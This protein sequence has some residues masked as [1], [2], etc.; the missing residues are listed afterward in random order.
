M[1]QG[2]DPLAQ[3]EQKNEWEVMEDC[4]C[5]DIDNVAQADTTDVHTLK[6]A[7]ET[8]LKRKGIDVG[9]FVVDQRGAYFKQCTREEAL[10]A[11]EAKKGSTMYVVADPDAKKS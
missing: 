7:C 8:Q 11:K 5:P 3:E 2:F 4:D 10:S 6:Q 9:V 1:A